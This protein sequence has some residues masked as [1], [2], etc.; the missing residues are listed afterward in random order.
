MNAAKATAAADERRALDAR[1]PSEN[2]DLPKEPGGGL[3][4]TGA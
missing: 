1:T 3:G 2:S 4:L